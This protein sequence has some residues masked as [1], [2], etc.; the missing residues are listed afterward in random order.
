MALTA[1]LLT[2][3]L[4]THA[5]TIRRAT[6]GGAGDGSGDSW[7]NAMTFKAALSASTT[8]GDQ[9][10]V[11][12]G[13]YTPH[14]SDQTVLFRIP[15]GVTVYGGFAGTETTFDP[16]TND[17]RPRDSDGVL[18]SVTFL[19]GDLNGDDGT[20][21]AADATPDQITAYNDRRDD[22]SHSVVAILGINATLNGLT[23]TNGV[24]GGAARIAAG[25]YSIYAGTTLID[26]TFSNNTAAEDG[27]GAYFN[28]S[29]VTL[30]R[31]TFTNNTAGQN[32]GGVY[33]NREVGTITDCTFSNNTATNAGGGAY[34]KGVP[35]L[36]DCTFSNNTATNAPGGGAYF[37]GVAIL[38]TT[39]FTANTATA[40]NGGG[41]YFNAKG[42]LTGCTFTDN[43]AQ[44]IG[45]GAF[46]S[47]DGTTLTG[48][49]F[50]R[51]T[52]TTQSGGGVYFFT[53]VTL[54][55]CTFT[56]NTATALNGG[57]AFFNASATLTNTTFTGTTAT[58]PATGALIPSAQNGAG[59]YF[60]AAATLTNTNFDINTAS[61][62]GGGA[63]FNATATLTGGTFADNISNTN[64]F[65][66][67]GAFFNATAT[68]TGVTF[69]FNRATFQN[70]GG[71]YFSTT[72]T[73]TLTGCTFT[74]NTANE[75]MFGGGGGGGYFNAPATL[76]RCSFTSNE[77]TS[78]NG[79][80][81]Y[82]I[83][84]ATLTSCS[85]TTNQADYG[86]ATY[87]T[88]KATLT[89]CVY[90]RNTATNR[91]G[92]IRL[93]AG[94]TITNST[95]Y[96][97]T[98]TN[99]GGAISVAFTD[100]DPDGES[101]IQTF[102]F[103]LRNSIFMSNTARDNASGNQIYVDNTDSGTNSGTQDVTLDRNL[104]A[105]GA[106]PGGMDQGVVYAARN[107]TTQQTLTNPESDPGTVFASTTS[108]D[109]N[110]LRLKA[111]GPAVNVG[112]NDYLNNDTPD[113]PDDDLR[114][115][116]AGV[117]RKQGGTVDLGAYESAAKGTQTTDFTLPTAGVVG[118]EVPLTATATS[119]LPVTYASSA[120]TVAAVMDD[121]AGGFV[122]EILT[123]GTATITASQSGDA[124]YEAAP[125]VEQTI[126]VR[127]L[128][129]FRVT[130]AGTDAG[131]G[132]WASPMD[133]QT[134]L[135]AANAPGDQ[136]W[137]K[138]GEYK[139][140]AIATDATPTAEQQAISFSIA[141]GVA[142]YGGF[143]GTE[144][145]SFDPA[146]TPR[147]GGGGGYH[148]LWR[149]KGQ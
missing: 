13:T 122:L 135:A 114:I 94:G 74:S 121:G 108:A 93:R 56:A 81:A 82:F 77:A 50:D 31:C 110:Y 71:A 118:A 2:T 14:A 119:G 45:G 127:D 99:N 32:G 5:Q 143:A 46:F 64:E 40:Q 129:I 20:P 100:T 84:P 22:N 19:S 26:C 12:T 95:F 39:T 128:S 6:T 24:N 98:A 111:D 51:N 138:T 47:G 133:L 69:N 87:F 8:E 137:I 61:E 67:G 59:A 7:V 88:K 101:G 124:T 80:G 4:S 104:I 57:G 11:A 60:N 52:A 112:D 130:T 30:T 1:I 149:S 86:G 144:P 75:N 15:V 90:D 23:I 21:P 89:N 132:T 97:N 58:D 38:T 136:V 105:G 25:L 62:N 139:P 91:S 72:A 103:I 142:V 145:D 55:D 126:T 66:G 73:A 96:A 141:P 125:D 3:L 109:P 148:P 48:T 10:W 44:T 115:D 34:F 146:T 134:A 116:L 9:I 147:T 35:T 85:F 92:A 63:Y 102:P 107:R 65:G 76:T 43:T 113:D 70:G 17:T 53:A 68:L 117:A 78:H 37:E 131:T 27:G 29:G 123:A 106:D 140:I 83:E 42:T 36:T 49:T 54:D 41:A 16:A 120:P 33:F 79:G 18:T 28:I